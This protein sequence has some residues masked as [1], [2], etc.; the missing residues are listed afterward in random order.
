[1]V[2][3]EIAVS[4]EIDK[5]VE[6]MIKERQQIIKVCKEA[7]EFIQKKRRIKMSKINTNIEDKLYRKENNQ[8]GFNSFVVLLA[9]ISIHYLD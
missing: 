2:N 7:Y 5:M 1:M 8:R 4:K 9:V 3:L 6:E